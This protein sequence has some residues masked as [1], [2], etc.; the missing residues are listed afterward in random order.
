MY[1]LDANGNRIPA[2]Q[3]GRWKTYKVNTVD[4][5]DRGNAEIWR[6]AAANAINEALREAGFTKGF[7]DHRSYARQGR[8]CI[9]L[10]HEGSEARA[11]QQCGIPTEVS[12]RNREIREQNK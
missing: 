3:K 5:D 9:P 4:W 2:R 8:E 10:I 1:N 6:A 12:E 7:V 11:M